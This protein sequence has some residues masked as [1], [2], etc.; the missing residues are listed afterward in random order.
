MIP[1]PPHRVIRRTN[2][3]KR[4]YVLTLLRDPEWVAQSDTVIAKDA[5]VTQPF[6]SKLRK[7]EEQIVESLAARVK[8]ESRVGKDGR[9]YHPHR[10]SAS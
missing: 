9:H 8:D 3:D 5:G 7:M 2:A 10:R 6:V 1:N 4:R